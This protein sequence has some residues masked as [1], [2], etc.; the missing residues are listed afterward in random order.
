[1][2]YKE[3]KKEM[4]RYKDAQKRLGCQYVDWNELFDIIERSTQCQG[5]Q[6]K[7]APNHNYP[8]ACISCSRFYGDMYI[9]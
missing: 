9:E 7:P 5:C 8:E 4:L 2:T 3:V 6:Y 1:M